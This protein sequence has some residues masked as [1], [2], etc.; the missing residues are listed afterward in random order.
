MS[1][2]GAIMRKFNETERFLLLKVYSRQRMAHWEKQGYVPAKLLRHISGLIGRPVDDLLRDFDN[3]V[4]VNSNG[5][6]DVA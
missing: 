6:N 2:M 3:N 4:E 1:G 5:T